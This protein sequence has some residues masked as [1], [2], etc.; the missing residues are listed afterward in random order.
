MKVHEALSMS[1]HTLNAR[2]SVLLINLCP[3]YY[4]YFH[5]NLKRQMLNDK[6]AFIL[7]YSLIK[8]DLRIIETN[9]SFDYY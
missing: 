3:N 7:E 5:T 6:H 4:I 2:D 1:N 8:P 9:T